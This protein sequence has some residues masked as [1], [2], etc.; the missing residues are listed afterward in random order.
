MTAIDTNN[1]SEDLLKEEVRS[2]R[3]MVIKPFPFYKTISPYY[4]E[5]TEHYIIFTDFSKNTRVLLSPAFE[6]YDLQFVCCFFTLKNT[7]FCYA[8]MG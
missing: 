5:Q 4:L 8:R 1:H 2:P 6:L 3:S 7:S